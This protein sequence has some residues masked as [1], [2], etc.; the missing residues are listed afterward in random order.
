MYL[1]PTKESFSLHPPQHPISSSSHGLKAQPWRTL[2]I[3]IH[4]L[5]ISGFNFW[6]ICSPNILSICYVTWLGGS[7]GKEKS[8]TNEHLSLLSLESRL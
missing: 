4:I 1:M 3:L 8:N 5:C 6:K 7:T 2:T